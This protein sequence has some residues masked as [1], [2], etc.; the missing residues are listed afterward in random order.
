[1]S[2]WNT[3]LKSLKAK[4]HTVVES[5]R[6]PIEE[7]K[8]GRKQL[9]DMIDDLQEKYLSSLESY[10]SHRRRVNE[11]TKKRDTELEKARVAK[12]NGNERLA[13]TLATRANHYDDFVKGANQD[14]I[15]NYQTQLEEII[16]DLRTQ[17]V[18]LEIEIQKLTDSL[19]L[20]DLEIQNSQ[21]QHGIGDPNNINRVL[22]EARE[23]VAQL[24]DR[25][26]ANK[27]AVGIFGRTEDV[28]ATA[29][30]KETLASL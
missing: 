13:I 10:H 22:D 15:T 14:N 6:D 25:A 1:M 24:Q 30:A 17:D 16:E 23:K 5:H 21:F 9:K 27:D 19:D 11:Y 12:A 20:A 26:S 18:G 2:I 7:L 3:I 4:T 28:N 8:Y 29:R